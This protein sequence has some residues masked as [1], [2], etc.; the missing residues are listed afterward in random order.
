V[1]GHR[2]G[3][4]RRRD[5]AGQRRSPSWPARRHHGLEQRAKLGRPSSSMDWA[6]VMKMD[7]SFYEILNSAVT[8]KNHRKL[9]RADKIMKNCVY[10]FHDILYL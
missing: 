4:R 10:A 3:G 8:C 7:F 2:W 9:S 1:L 5:V 6:G